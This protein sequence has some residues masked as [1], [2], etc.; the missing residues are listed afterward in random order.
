MTDDIYHYV[1]PLPEGIDEAVLPCYSGYTIYTADRLTTEERKRAFRHALKHIYK[2]D[3][4]EESVQK[5][6]SEM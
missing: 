3:W 2:N 1:V 4:D 6:E 5:I